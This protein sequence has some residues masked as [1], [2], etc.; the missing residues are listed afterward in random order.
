MMAQIGKDKVLK[1]EKKKTI[2]RI[3]IV[4]NSRVFKDI[5]NGVNIL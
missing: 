3:V 2:N 5:K 4:K 1:V